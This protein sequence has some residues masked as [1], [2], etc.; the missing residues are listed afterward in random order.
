MDELT[1]EQKQEIL[2]SLGQTVIRVVRDSPLKIAMHI[3]MGTT[4]NPGK[5]KQ[6]EAL[7][8][9]SEPQKES[10]CDL[11]SEIITA[12]IYYFMEMFEENSDKMKFII[13]KDGQEYN[14]LDIS[15]KMGSEIACY[16][17]EGWIQRFSS[18]GRFV[19]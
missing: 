9:L 11:L 5:R 19:L 3:V 18:I 17:D 6:Y 7:S 16:E 8:D 4:V 1:K 15:E 13:I 2:D 12:V 10:V 14:M